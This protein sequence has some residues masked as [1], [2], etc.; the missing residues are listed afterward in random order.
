[1][2]KMTDQKKAKRECDDVLDKISEILF[3]FANPTLVEQL[4]EKWPKQFDKLYDNP[5]PKDIQN[6]IKAIR[7]KPYWGNKVNYRVKNKLDKLRLI[8][9]KLSHPDDHDYIGFL[10]ELHE[11]KISIPSELGIISADTKNTLNQIL[12]NLTRQ[13]IDLVN[14]EPSKS[15]FRRLKGSAGSGKTLVVAARAVEAASKE[16]RV[17]VL[18]YSKPLVKKIESIIES[19]QDK[20]DLDYNIH[21]LKIKTFYS[22]LYDFCKEELN[23]VIGNNGNYKAK[24]DIMINKIH[25]QFNEEKYQDQTFDAIYIDEA[26]NFEADWW[27]LIRKFSNHK[28]QEN[29]ELFIAADATQDYFGTSNKKWTDESMSGCGFKG[30]WRTLDNS[31]RMHP[32]AVKLAKIFIDSYLPR[33]PSINHPE[34]TS[35]DNLELDLNER[36]KFSFMWSDCT[37]EKLNSLVCKSIKNI[38]NKK[39]TNA[40]ILWLFKTPD[41]S[42][43]AKSITQALEAD[44]K[45]ES[46]YFYI[47]K[48]TEKSGVNSKANFFLQKGDLGL[49]S[50]QSYQGLESHNIIIVLDYERKTNFVLSSIYVAI[51][52]TL[53]HDECS[54]VHIINLS[55]EFH[56]MGRYLTKK[57]EA[58]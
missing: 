55:P 49:I 53:I 13:Q 35:E 22:F 28:N 12:D 46:D 43:I 23:F 54:S 8:R 5:S 3:S 26:Q 44:K 42:A 6:L 14:E 52:R 39:E 45:E 36:G 20:N 50:S 41:E 1:M 30:P 2:L 15:G 48:T 29:P 27:K 56:R 34:T 17:L 37:K 7:Q 40:V 58:L 47:Q 21:D 38:N 57:F 24:I 31:Y 25:E 51:T 16:K 19:Y 11:L 10:R 18:V 9:N 32:K 33:N 4:G